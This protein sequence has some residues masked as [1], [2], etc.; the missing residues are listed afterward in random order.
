M[1]RTM[2]GSRDLFRPRVKAT[3][4]EKVQSPRGKRSFIRVRIEGL[5]GSGKGKSYTAIPLPNQESLASLSI[6][7]GLMLVGEEVE[8]LPM[9][10]TVDVLLLSKP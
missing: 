6:A 3:V 1:V 8:E 4:K 9:G 5:E 2:L 7:H 10:T